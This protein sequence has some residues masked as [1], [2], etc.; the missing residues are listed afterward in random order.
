[1]HPPSK[2]AYLLTRDHFQLKIEIFTSKSGKKD[3]YRG[4]H[5]AYHNKP[6]LKWIVIKLCVT[7][8]T[9]AYRDQHT[10][11]TPIFVYLIDRYN[12]FRLVKIAAL[13]GYNLA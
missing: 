9:D 3:A 5:E 13:C 11:Y 1:M 6:P 7:T 2:N 12:M 4:K 10:F 8:N